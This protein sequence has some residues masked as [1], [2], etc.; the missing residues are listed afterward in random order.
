MKLNEAMKMLKQAW[1]EAPRTSLGDTPDGR[2]RGAIVTCPACR[3]PILMAQPGSVDHLAHHAALAKEQPLRFWREVA[4]LTHWLPVPYRPGGV[5]NV[6]V[7]GAD[8]AKAFHPLTPHEGAGGVSA[9]E[10]WASMAA[11]SPLA[12]SAGARAQAAQAV[13]FLRTHEDILLLAGVRLEGSPRRGYWLIHE[14][15]WHELHGLARFDDFKAV[16]RAL[17]RHR[18][19]VRLRDA[20]RCPEGIP[21]H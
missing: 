17:Y 3:L 7:G 20:T 10:D 11:L 2:H 1:L 9:R 19:N 13:D 6:M 4:P 14:D 15:D 16:A 18:A 12:V 5:R 8:D 21:T